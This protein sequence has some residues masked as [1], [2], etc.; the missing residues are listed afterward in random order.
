MLIR[1]QNLMALAWARWTLVTIG[2]NLGEANSEKPAS[3]QI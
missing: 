2:Q 3:N 1:D